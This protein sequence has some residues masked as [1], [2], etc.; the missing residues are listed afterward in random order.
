VT[1]RQLSP[2]G[3]VTVQRRA[4]N[5][6]VI[7]V[8]GQ[9]IALGRNDPR[10]NGQVRASDADRELA[11]EALRQ[12]AGDGRLTLEELDQRLQPI[13]RGDLTRIPAAGST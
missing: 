6:G 5:V 10:R 4:S 9:K 7:V 12:A 2:A 3:P 11:A 8:V 1:H 13:R